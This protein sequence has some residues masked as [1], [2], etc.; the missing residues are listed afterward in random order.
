MNLLVFIYGVIAVCIWVSFTGREFF[1]R[2]RKGIPVWEFALYLIASALW[3]ITLLVNWIW[4][5]E[6][7]GT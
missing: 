1:Q 5:G 6:N 2:G 3:P 4:K 7:D